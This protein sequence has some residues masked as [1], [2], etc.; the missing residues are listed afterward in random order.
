MNL[1]LWRFQK[2][3]L[4]YEIPVIRVFPKKDRARVQRPDRREGWRR[5]AHLPDG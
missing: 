4:T 1:Q 3:Q 2:L 5:V